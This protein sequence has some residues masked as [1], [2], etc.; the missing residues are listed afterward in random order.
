MVDYAPLAQIFVNYYEILVRNAFGNLRTILKEVS[1]NGV[2]SSYLTFQ[3]SA[4]L[5]VSGTVPDENVNR[6]APNINPTDSLLRPPPCKIL[7]S[8]C[9]HMFPHTTVWLLTS[10]AHCCLISDLLHDGS[11]RERACSCSPSA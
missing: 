1:Y 10:G 6:L 8:P 5:A 2:M 7:N 3:D 4:S 11:M 9:L